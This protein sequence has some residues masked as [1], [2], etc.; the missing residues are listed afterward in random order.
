M[1]LL[2][3]KVKPR[4]DFS[5][6]STS[7][8]FLKPASCPI[9]TSTPDSALPEDGPIELSFSIPSFISTDDDPTT[10]EVATKVLL[11]DTGTTPSSSFAPS[12]VVQSVPKNWSKRTE[13]KKT[14]KEDAL[15]SLKSMTLV[16]ANAPPLPLQTFLGGLSVGI[17]EII[18][19]KFTTTIKASLNHQTIYDKTIPNS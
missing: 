12:I 9:D 19:Y 4:I 1:Y 17:I 6:I 8:W 3:E 7:G 2:P 13:T 15:E 11:T 18:M 14:L 10:L 5:S 16:E